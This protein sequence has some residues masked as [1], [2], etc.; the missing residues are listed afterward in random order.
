M[1]KVVGK[2]GTMHDNAALRLV[3]ELKKIAIRH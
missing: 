1:A 3:D 2:M